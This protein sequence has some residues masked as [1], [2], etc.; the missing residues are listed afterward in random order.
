MRSPEKAIFRKELGDLF[1]ARSTLSLFVLSSFLIGYGFIQAVD[2]FTEASRAAIDHKE[3]ASGMNP[4]EGILVPT[5]GSLYLITTLLFPFVAIHSISNE[6]QTSTLKILLQLPVPFSRILLIK[7]VGVFFCWFLSTVPAL[8]AIGLWLAWGGHVN[9]GEY[10]T[11]M[12]GHALYAFA[13]LGISFL[14]AAITQSSA[15]AAL[16]VLAVTLG[17]WVLDF[18]VSSHSGSWVKSLSFLSLTAS[19]RPFERGLVLSESVIRLLVV[20][21]VTGLSG[22]LWLS[23]PGASAKSRLRKVA[24]VAMT[25][26]FIGIASSFVPL[27]ADL[28]ED[29]RNSFAAEHETLLRNIQGKLKIRIALSPDDPRFKDIQRNVLSKLERAVPDVSVSVVTTGKSSMFGVGADDA[30]GLNEFEY[31]GK[32]ETSRSTSP[33]EL[34]PVIYRLAGMNA[35]E[36]SST[37]Y[38]GYPLIANASPFGWL[39]YLALPLCFLFLWWWHHRIPNFHGGNSK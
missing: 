13:I 33:K 18:S 20:G 32:I 29:R 5:L 4:F 3:L 24:A 7:W 30:Y 17:S 28:S 36:V 27:H 6:R 12:L 15:S 35:P 31:Q 39:F 25:C 16:L 37:A 19:I 11:L 1:S 38:S 8:L 10:F 9:V 23:Q 21:L 34:L 14:I 26:L 22:F 2:L